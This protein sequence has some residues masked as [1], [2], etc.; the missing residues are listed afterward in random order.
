MNKQPQYLSPELYQPS[1]FLFHAFLKEGCLFGEGGEIILFQ[2]I[3]KTSYQKQ[4]LTRIAFFTQS[5]A[6]RRVRL[7]QG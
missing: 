6:Q 2:G 4:S 7:Q 5:Q 3:H 1:G